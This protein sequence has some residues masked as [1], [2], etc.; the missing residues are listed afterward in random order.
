MDKAKRGTTSMRGVNASPGTNGE[1]NATERQEAISKM[2]EQILGTEAA[3]C[4]KEP[5]P[6]CILELAHLAVN[7]ERQENYGSQTTNFTNIADM[8]TVILREKLISPITPQDV[9]MC[10]VG[11]KLARLTKTGGCHRD[12]IIDIAGYAECLDKVNQGN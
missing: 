6:K 9:T 5:T 4:N 8:W 12:S 2:K 3:A 11:L 7:G 10:Q 1:R